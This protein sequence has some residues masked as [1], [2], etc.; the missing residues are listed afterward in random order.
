MQEFVVA[1]ERNFNGIEQ[2][3][4]QR[5]CC[6]FLE[7]LTNRGCLQL[8][9]LVGKNVRHPTDVL[10]EATKADNV[11]HTVSER[12]RFKLIIDCTEDDSIMRLLG[13]MGV[14]ELNSKSLFMLSNMLEDKEL[15]QL[16]LVSGV[17]F[18]ALQGK[19]A[20]L[21]Q[22]E[23]VNE[24]FYDL[25]N[26]HFRMVQGRNGEMSLFAN[27]AVGG[28]SRRSQ[29]K[30]EF[31]CIVHIRESQ[32]DKMPAPFLNR[33]E[34]F[35]LK[36]SDVLSGRCRLLG[37]LSNYM[38]K[39]HSRVNLLV[40]TLGR[41]GLFGFVDGQTIDSIFISM[42]PDRAT[43][44]S[45]VLMPSKAGDTREARSF[46]E[47]FCLFLSEVMSQ[48]YD[49]RDHVSAVIE[50]AR[51]TLPTDLCNL[52]VDIVK[53]PTVEDGFIRECFASLSTGSNQDD[54][55]MGK[56]LALLFQMV[57]TRIA[58]FRLMQIATPE[59]VFFHR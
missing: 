9:S 44:L 27:I 1:V 57:V 22:T 42:L 17:K 19:L 15:E 51:N 59:A 39:A 52:L 36:T 21:S 40:A 3:Q 41:K 30:Q 38:M 48:L 20:V 14:V 32:M 58:A 56:L 33:F 16:R 35:R 26:Q 12:T 11:A 23:A 6:A 28:V 4:L 53:L 55:R 24:C 45:S 8:T 2:K 50:D 34:K 31:S 29:V 5:I 43:P 13:V 7:K 18:A 37:N 54:S 10:V 25:F 46:P 49:I 47:L